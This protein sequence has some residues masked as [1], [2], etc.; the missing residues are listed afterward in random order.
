MFVDLTDFRVARK[1]HPV[2]GKISAISR[3]FEQH[4]SAEWVWWLDM[5]AI[6]MAPHLN[7][8]D[9]VLSP[10]A[11]RNHLLKDTRIKTNGEVPVHSM[12]EIK[13]PMV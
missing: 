5:D 3:A 1:L 11:M 2:W 9:H 12:P 8:Y 4:P 6:I 13:T 10:S 7:L